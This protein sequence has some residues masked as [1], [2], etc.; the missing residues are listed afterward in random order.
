VN[1]ERWGIRNIRSKKSFRQQLR[2]FGTPAEAVLWKSLQSRQIIGKRFRRQHSI[3]RYVVDFYCP[4]SRLIV[5]LDGDYHFSP[6]IEGYEEERTRFLETLGLRVLRFENRDVLE[7]L[8][9]V[10]ETIKNN[11]IE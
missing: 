6:T 2:S 5:E 1:D 11:L 8:E 10:L 7:N 9:G 3:G 4:E